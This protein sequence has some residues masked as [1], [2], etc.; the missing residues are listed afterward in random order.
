MKKDLVDIIIL[1][2]DPSDPLW[3]SDFN[4]HTAVP[5]NSEEVALRYRDWGTLKYV[6]RGIAENL[7]WVNNIHFI[8]SGH[9]PSWLDTDKV[10]HHKHADIFKYKDALPV[11]NASSIELN[12]DMVPGLSD[13]FI[14]FNDDTVILSPLAQS[15]FFEKGLPVDIELYNLPKDNVFFRKKYQSVDVWNSMILNC[16][17]LIQDY[18]YHFKIKDVP[19]NIPF[20]SKILNKAYTFIPGYKFYSH[21]HQPMP[22]LRSTIEKVNNDFCDEVKNTIYSRFRHEGN[23]SQAIYRYHQ[24]YTGNYTPVYYNDHFVY[25]LKSYNDVMAINLEKDGY[26]IVCL[27]DKYQGERFDESKEHVISMLDKILPRESIYEKIR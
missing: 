12:F 23:I 8:T 14:Y 21:Y 4:E 16:H 17:R 10:I 18:G 5:L 15:R 11:F 7:P 9:R 25:S 26:S 13:K 1:W 19:A 24:L 3:L 2:V 22:L 27:N 20:L 6:F